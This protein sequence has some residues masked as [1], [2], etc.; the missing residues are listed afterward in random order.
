MSRKFDII[1]VL[2]KCNFYFDQKKKC[3]FC[4]YNDIETLPLY[5]DK[6]YGQE[7]HMLFLKF[8][9]VID[10]F[11]CKPHIFKKHKSNSLL[12]IVIN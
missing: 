7:I 5:I 2:F 8:Q 12:L 9:K 11:W 4:A 10:Y 6:N 3:N 1:I